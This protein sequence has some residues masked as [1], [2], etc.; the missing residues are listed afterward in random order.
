MNVP[1]LGKGSSV[2]SPTVFIEH[3]DRSLD[4]K[5]IGASESKQEG[6]TWISSMIIIVAYMMGIG[7]LGLAHA[8]SKVGWL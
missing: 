1:L 5:I 7:V 4:S 3:S 2:F 6:A 8:F